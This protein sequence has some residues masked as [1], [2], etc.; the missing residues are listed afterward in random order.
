VDTAGLQ[1]TARV[2]IQLLLCVLSGSVGAVSVKLFDNTSRPGTLQVSRLELVDTRKNVRASLS[3]EGD[4]SVSLRLFSQDKSLVVTLAARSTFA[5]NKAGSYGTLSLGNNQGRPLVEL[6]SGETTGGKLTFSSANM[7]DQV[8]V[9]YSKYGDVEDGHDRGAWGLQ[10][11]GPEH[12][13]TGLNVFSVDGV[14]QGTTIPL[15]APKSIRH[16]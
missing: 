5:G 14:L 16:Q 3:A 10:I 9:G 8:T 1:M 6:R 4:G 2:S 7:P 11:A 12:S 15:E 13:K